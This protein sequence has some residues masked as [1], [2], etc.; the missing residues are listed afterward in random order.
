LDVGYV[1]IDL[2]WPALNAYDAATGTKVPGRD[3]FEPEGDAQW[4]EH[5]AGT[6]TADQYWDQVARSRGL[7]GLTGLFRA[8][9]EVVPD[10]LFDRGA[11]ALMRDASAAGRRVGVLSNDAYSFIGKEFFAGRSEFAE[12]DAFVDSTELGVRKP[13]PEA[14]LAAAEALA[15][16]PDSI[17]FLDD[18][19]ECVEGAGR[20]GM[21]GILVDPFDRTPAFDRARELLGLPAPTAVP[22]RN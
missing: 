10:E 7:D 15:S 4:Q 8:L 20:V 13:A 18:T 6:I 16:A 17:V 14:Y 3:P 9:A 11:V 19:P 22:T 2:S 12:L 21:V 1:I 5:L